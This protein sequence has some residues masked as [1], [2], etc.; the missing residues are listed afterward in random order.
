MSSKKVCNSMKNSFKITPIVK[1]KSTI[2]Y[3]R[4]VT[5]ITRFEIP[6]IHQPALLYSAI[7]YDVPLMDIH[8][9]IHS[10]R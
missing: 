3:L 1:V 9:E 7:Q 2:A 10:Q 5:K 6:V 8:S 4:P